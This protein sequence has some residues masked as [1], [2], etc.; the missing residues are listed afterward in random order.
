M[1][2]IFLSTVLYMRKIEKNNLYKIDN[3]EKYKLF[4]TIAYIF[5]NRMLLQLPD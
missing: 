1:N 2:K 3:P 5:C 4:T